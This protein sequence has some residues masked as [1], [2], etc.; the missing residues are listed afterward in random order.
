MKI[1]INKC[2]G[3]FGLSQA[4][5]ERLRE[6]GVP[7]VDYRN[8][9]QEYGSVIF[10]GGMSQGRDYLWGYTPERNDPLLLQVLEEL[11]KDAWGSFAKLEVVEI[12]DDVEW[13]IQEY[14]GV[15]WVA[16]AHRTWS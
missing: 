11:G 8:N 7:V 6:L 1:V 12:P 16:E 3:G 14:D 15:E 10:R 4:A 13:G 2:Y 9:D 5:L